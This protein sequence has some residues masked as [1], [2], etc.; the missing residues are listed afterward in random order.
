MLEFDIDIEIN[1]AFVKALEAAS[2]TALEK[3]GEDIRADLIVSQTMP[4]DTGLLQNESTYVDYEK[5]KEGEIALVSNT[6]YARRLYFHPEYKFRTDKNPNA[7]AHWFDPY[8]A[9]HEKGDFAGKAFA[10]N[11]KKGMQGWIK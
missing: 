4:L 8:L 7:G 11:L 9:G 5:A 6:P 3:T 2:I 1:P 10:H